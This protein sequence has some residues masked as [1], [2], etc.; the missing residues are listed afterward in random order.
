MSSITEI[1]DFD[2][3]AIGP[4]YTAN[5]ASRSSASVLN[6]KRTHF[7]PAASSG[8]APG[9]PAGLRGSMFMP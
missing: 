1:P 3:A 9:Q 7:T 8:S 5:A 4:S 2:S 6:T